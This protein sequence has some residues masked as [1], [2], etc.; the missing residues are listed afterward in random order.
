MKVNIF[1]GGKNI[2]EDSSLLQPNEAVIFTNINNGKRILQSIAGP[3]KVSPEQEVRGYFYNFKDDWL[4]SSA[5]RT[6]LEYNDILYFTEENQI[7]KKF[8]GNV[9]VPLGIAKPP[10]AC[11][12][13][14]AD[15]T[16]TEEISASSETLQ[17]TYTYYSE[18]FGIEGP[19]ADLSN[20][21]SLEASKVVDLTN[22]I[23]PTDN[24]VTHIYI[25]RLGAGTTEFTKHSEILLSDLSEPVRD[26]LPSID[27]QGDL[28]ESDDYYPPPIDLKFITEAYGILFGA[29]GNKLYFSRTGLPDAWPPLY[30]I[31]FSRA[32]TGIV[33][34]DEGLL[35]QS[36]YRTDILVGDDPGNFAKLP[37]ST[38]HGCLHNS[39]NQEV[40]SLPVWI[41]SDGI[42]AYESGR[43]NVVSR[44]KLCHQELDVINTITHDEIYYILLTDYS[45]LVMDTRFGIIFK[46]IKFTSKVTN[47]HMHEDILY[48]SIG[49]KLYILDT[50]DD[51]ELE[52]LSPVFT[53]N[54]HA[55]IKLYNNIYI[56]ADGT[57][58]FKAYIDGEE[59]INKKIE[60]NKI[61]DVKVPEK[62]QRG[63]NIQVYFKGLGKI[64]EYEYKVVGRQNGR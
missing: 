63:S 44:N 2:R 23:L 39:T 15:P 11:I 62:K 49:E 61:H 10:E 64:Y 34:I 14:Q 45:M 28:L 52:Y 12:A 22:F 3:A 53:E 4:S 54:D 36:K 7:P 17:Y 47:V 60:G 6:Y 5:Y 38:K 27:L 25:Y 40:N 56:R 55:V 21:L 37:L 43:I 30:Y 59:V 8:N 31:E 48:A 35:V 18:D 1:D 20:E 26:D 16:A 58:I 9:T 32:I 57:F 33:P 24:Q 13:T 42:V 50:G 46:N 41:S 51:L 19:P 29:S